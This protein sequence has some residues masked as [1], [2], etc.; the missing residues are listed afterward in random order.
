MHTS[1]GVETW[2]NEQTSSTYSLANIIQ[3]DLMNI[4]P[5]KENGNRGVKYSNGALG[6]TRMPNFGI[7]VEVAYHDYE[8]DAYWIMNNKEL[9]GNTLADSIL[10]Y[11]GIIS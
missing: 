1:K 7:L 3:N 2:I 11:F 4:Y 5:D 9:I 10:K 8:E 6:E